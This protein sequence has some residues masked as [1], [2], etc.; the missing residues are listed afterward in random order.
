MDWRLRYHPGVKDDVSGFPRNIKKSIRL[1]INERL[2][3]NPLIGL[4]LRSSLKGYRKLRIGNYRVIYLIRKPDI[5]IL[6]I[7]HRSDVYKRAL[8]G[9]K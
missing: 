1:A 9:N 5:I 6:L 4:P 3:G 7:G 8:K 2:M